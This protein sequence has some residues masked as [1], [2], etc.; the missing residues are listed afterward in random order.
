MCD[1]S[2]DVFT[3]NIFW[4]NGSYHPTPAGYTQEAADLKTHLAALNY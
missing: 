1:P 3:I 2:P 4:L